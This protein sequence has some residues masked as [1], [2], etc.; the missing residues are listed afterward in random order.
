MY[1]PVV[2]DP[3]ELRLNAAQQLQ[4]EEVLTQ[5]ISAP[6]AGAHA[7][8][9]GVAADRHR[10]MCVFTTRATQHTANSI[11]NNEDGAIGKR[12]KQFVQLQ[13][14]ISSWLFLFATLIQRKLVMN[15]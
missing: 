3:A 7:E 14:W 8:E 6:V 9:A 13:D 15:T 11:Q 10:E 2:N 4:L 12:G 1:E 5:A